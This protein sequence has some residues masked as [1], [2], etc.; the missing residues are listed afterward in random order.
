MTVHKII[1][2]KKFEINIEPYIIYSKVKF[3]L[4]QN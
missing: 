2:N 1:F 3:S 4:Q